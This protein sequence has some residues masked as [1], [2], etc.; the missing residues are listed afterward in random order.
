MKHKIIV[1]KLPEGSSQHSG[2]RQNKLQ[3]LRAGVLTFFALS[4]VIGIFLAA[5]VVGSIIA[6]L[7]LI[8]F[9]LSI[10]AGLVRYLFVWFGRGQRNR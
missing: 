10:L 7:L 8:L 9:A 3:L 6:S 1:W 2:L 4:V 5:F